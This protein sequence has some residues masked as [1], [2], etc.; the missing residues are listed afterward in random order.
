MAQ[1]VYKDADRAP[2]Y[3]VVSPSFGDVERALDV[4]G[5]RGLSRSSW[6][7]IIK[8][9]IFCQ[10]II[11]VACWIEENIEDAALRDKAYTYVRDVIEAGGIKSGIKRCK[12]AIIEFIAF[13]N[14]E[15]IKRDL[16]AYFE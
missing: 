16:E 10:G 6:S 1:Q 15:D 5:I 2:G 13:M 3:Y 4:F 12:T 11:H 7:K 14:E 8:D 9:D